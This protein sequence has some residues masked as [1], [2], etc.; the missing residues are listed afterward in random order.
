MVGRVDQLGSEAASENINPALLKLAGLMQMGWPGAPTLYYGD[1]A[2]VV[3]FT[4]PDNRRTYP[5]DN[6]DYVLI[7][8][9]RDLIAFHKNHVALKKG[10]FMFLSTGRNYVSFARFTKDEKVIIIV[11]SGG[12]TMELSIPVWKAEI[13]ATCEIN[14]VFMTNVLGYS[15]FPVR[16]QVQ[17]GHVHIKLL[18]FSGVALCYTPEA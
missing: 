14:Q 17:G 2:G 5:W 9:H 4:D 6:P 15:L 11:N 10:S 13:P 8:Y 12:D 1:E 7:D 18:P 3:G 16:H